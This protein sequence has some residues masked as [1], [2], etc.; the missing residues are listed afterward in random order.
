MDPRIIRLRQIL[1]RDLERNFPNPTPQMWAL[2][3]EDYL[4]AR[5]KYFTVR[6]AIESVRRGGTTTDWNGRKEEIV[7]NLKEEHRR[8]NLLSRIGHFR[9]PEPYVLVEGGVCVIWNYRARNSAAAHVFLRLLTPA[10]PSDLWDR[11]PRLVV[12]PATLRPRWESGRP[13]LVPPAASSS[14]S[15]GKKN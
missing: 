2:L 9:V 7:V 4:A 14:S 8:L 10:I 12:C 5:L 3:D 13:A 6:N 11:N 1:V 15:A